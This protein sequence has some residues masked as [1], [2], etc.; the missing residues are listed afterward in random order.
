MFE[1]GGRS[2]DVEKI[3]ADGPHVVALAPEV[4]HLLEDPRNRAASEAGSEVSV[5]FEGTGAILTGPY[6]PK[7]GTATVYIDG[8]LDRTVDVC[9]DESSNRG[10]ESVWH[11]F[12]LTD[13][14]HTIRLVVD[15]KPG[16]GSDRTD[17]VVDGLIVFK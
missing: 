2:R 10:G 12:G 8:K 14:K 6:L 4:L 11:M 15:G 17:V 7:G 1:D 9:S 13:G 3:G 16:P 5:T